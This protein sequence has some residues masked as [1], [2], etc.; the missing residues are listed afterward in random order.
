MR[1]LIDTNI[2]ISSIVWPNSKP[3]LAFFKAV[4]DPNRGIICE[5]SVDELRKVVSR[6]FPAYISELETFLVRNMFA[7]EFVPV[8][9][10]PQESERLIRD[11]DDRMILRAAISAKADILLTGDKDFLESSVEDPRIISVAEFLER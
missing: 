10:Y 11:K 4:N 7:L 2:L 9:L 3:S 6:K 5:Q 8:P 1:I